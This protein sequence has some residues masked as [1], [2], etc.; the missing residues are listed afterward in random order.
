MNNHY[1]IL[2]LILLTLFAFTLNLPF[3]YL[4]NKT[5]KFSFLWFLYIHLPIPF[6]IVF[7]LIA[8]FSMKIVPII[9]IASIAGQVIGAR[10]DRY[11]I[12]VRKSVNTGE[13]H[14]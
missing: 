13:R 9:L 1:S 12:K 2:L 11:R 3:G 4:R 10:I 5:K 7:R 6:V 14:E 8:G